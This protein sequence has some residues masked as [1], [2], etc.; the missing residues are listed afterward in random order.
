MSEAS[1]ITVWQ[2]SANTWDCD[3]MGHMNVRVYVEKAHEGLGTIAHALHLPRAFKANGF[4]TLLPTDQHIR[5][6]REALPG[7][8]LNMRACVLEHGECDALIYQE[9]CHGNGDVSAAFRTRVRHAEARSGRAFPWSDRSREALAA[10]VGA[11]PKA[12]APKSVDPSAPV[13]LASE[14]TVA[15]AEAAGAA[16]IG[17][18]MVPP[19][20]MDIHGRMAPQ[21]IMGRLS[22]SVPNLLYDWRRRVAESQGGMRMGG[23][24]LEYRLLYHRWPESG[25]LFEVRSSLARVEKKFHSIVHWV[26][27]PVSGLPWATAEAVAVTFDIDARKVIPTSK[28]LMDELAVIAPGG[29]TL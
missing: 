17:S 10:L 18:G 26:L 13:R 24:V 16:A 20:H 29:L 2:G 19:A 14:A 28:E 9:L 6:M 4:S 5:F 1:M 8:P 27:D 22:D 3:E 12:T 21:W 25:D 15:I 23:A 7:A 11:S